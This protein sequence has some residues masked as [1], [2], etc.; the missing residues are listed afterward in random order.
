MHHVMVIFERGITVRDMSV[1]GTVIVPPPPCDPP[2]SKAVAALCAPAFRHLAHDRGASAPRL[3]DSMTNDAGTYYVFAA[4]ID[5][6][7]EC[8]AYGVWVMLVDKTIHITQPVEG[9]FTYTY[10]D[11]GLVEAGKATPEVHWGPPLRVVVQQTSRPA[12]TYVLDESKFA[13]TVQ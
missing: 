8:G 13:L 2:P 9:C 12:H 7:G 4:V 5:G 6:S 11:S 3:I 1:D 10:D